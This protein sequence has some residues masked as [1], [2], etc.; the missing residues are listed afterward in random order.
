MKVKFKLFQRLIF[1]VLLVLAIFFAGIRIMGF[2]P[3]V[4]ETQSMEPNYP[5]DALIY[6]HDIEFN[7]L[8]VGDVISYT[9]QANLTVTHRITAINQEE[10]FVHT[11]GDAN[12]FEDILPVYSENIIGKVYFKIPYIGKIASQITQYFTE[13]SSSVE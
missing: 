7:E 1:P 2:Q 11:K 10:G 3:Y 6:V 8:V 9:N 5:V 13:R 12:E 4:I